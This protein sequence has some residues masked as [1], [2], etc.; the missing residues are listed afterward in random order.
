MLRRLWLALA[1]LFVAA[2]ALAATP[3]TDPNGRYAVTFPDGWQVAPDPTFMQ[4]MAAAPVKPTW[5]ESVKIVSADMPA[6]RS[7]KDYVDGSLAA[8]NSIW[9]VAERKAVP[10]GEELVMDQS[11][12]HTRLLK[13]FLADGSHVFVITCASKP[14]AF[15]KLR[16][17][18][19]A[20]VKSFRIL[21]PLPPGAT[22]DLVASD[23]VIP[24]PPRW[25]GGVGAFGV[26][27]ALT[28][29]YGDERVMLVVTHED[30]GV[31]GAIASTKQSKD[32]LL[33]EADTH[34]GNRPAH[35]LVFDHDDGYRAVYLV[36]EGD[37]HVTIEV[38]YGAG[39]IPPD[40]RKELDAMLR[41]WRWK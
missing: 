3:F 28:T 4:L 26:E 7:L 6:G 13:V 32:K 15:A 38:G 17:A 12:T 23:Y 30:G 34:I 1:A 31:A 5:G 21:P 37:R 29:G 33:S 19:E 22:L 8:Y 36:A 41:D 14:E 10:H 39:T 20:V 24:H 11:N 16:P 40:L 25:Q 18:Y 2:P 35:Q 9:T 27:A